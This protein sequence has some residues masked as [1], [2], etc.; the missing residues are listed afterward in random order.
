MIGWQRHVTINTDQTH[1]IP[2]LKFIWFCNALKFN[3]SS[4]KDSHD[5]ATI[6]RV[7]VHQARSSKNEQ[8]VM[9]SW[10]Y[11]D[12]EKKEVD[13]R[14]VHVTLLGAIS[15][16]ISWQYNTYLL[17]NKF[18][19]LHSCMLR[20]WKRLPVQVAWQL[21]CPKIYE[22]LCWQKKWRKRKFE[23]LLLTWY[24]GA[25]CIIILPFVTLLSHLDDSTCWRTI[26]TGIQVSF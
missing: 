26:K 12:E 21:L 5:L 1:E 4:H 25:P 11:Q 22:L 3:G 16:R 10:D 24:M 23:H 9:S 8:I 15:L 13:K 2:G 6:S 17:Q 14:W 20:W 7:H 19:S 18:L